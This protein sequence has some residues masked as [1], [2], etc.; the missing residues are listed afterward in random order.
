[1]N[2]DTQRYETNNWPKFL[3]LHN[4]IPSCI[5]C[6]WQN[7]FSRLGVITDWIGLNR[8]SSNSRIRRTSRKSVAAIYKWDLRMDRR[9]S[10]CNVISWVHKKLFFYIK[11]GPV[12]RFGRLVVG[13]SQ[14][15]GLFNSWPVNVGFVVDQVALR[16]YFGFPRQYYSS[17]FP[18]CHLPPTIHNLRNLQWR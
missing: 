9:T 12:L 14:R 7:I 11:Y 1:M 3:W 10:C 6:L 8:I 4:F 17:N 15:R 2:K 13:L 5:C 16:Q 18:L